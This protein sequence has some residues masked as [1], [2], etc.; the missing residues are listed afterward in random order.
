MTQLYWGLGLVMGGAEPSP[1]FSAA[2]NAVGARLPALD[3]AGKLSPSLLRQGFQGF[4]AARMLGEEASLPIPL[5]EKMKE[6]WTEKVR[7]CVSLQ[8]RVYLP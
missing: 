3:A 6:A 5:L 4:L 2:F 8:D 7:R 1:A